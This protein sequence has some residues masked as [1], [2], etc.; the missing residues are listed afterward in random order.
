MTAH[1]DQV[2]RDLRIKARFQRWMAVVLVAVD[3]FYFSA[4]S[5]SEEAHWPARAAQSSGWAFD[6]APLMARLGVTDHGVKS[7]RSWISFITFVAYSVLFTMNIM[8]RAV[9]FP[10]SIMRLISISSV[11]AYSW[12]SMTGYTTVLEASLP[13]TS[14]LFC[15]TP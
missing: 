7:A 14:F 9:R 15:L 10:A 4:L 6:V 11:L 12:F 5:V 8:S 3:V 2:L 13:L 1:H